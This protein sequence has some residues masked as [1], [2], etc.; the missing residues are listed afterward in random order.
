MACHNCDA[1]F[2]ALDLDA[3]LSIE[4]Q[5]SGINSETAPKW[6]IIRYQFP[7]RGKKPPVTM[8]WYDG[9]KLP[10]A[11]L[12]EGETL[13]KNGTILVGAKG[14]VVFRDWNPDGFRVLPEATFKDFQAPAPTLPRAPKGPYQEWIAAC[15]GGPK[16]LSNFEY[17]G[18]LTETVLLGIVAL[19]TGQR[20]DWNVRKLQARNCPAADA[21]IRR[22]YRKG[23]TL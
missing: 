17:A 3:P 18:R 21:Y 19:R 2:W 14:R 5:S 4:A 23:W 15:K 6:S 13:P 22:E 11:D 8:T 12:V 1:A 10:P 9:G 7:A 20:L 16:C